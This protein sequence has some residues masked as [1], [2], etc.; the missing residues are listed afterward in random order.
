MEEKP[1]RRQ[2]DPSKFKS[3]QSIESTG[4]YN[5][6]YNKWAGF[7]KDYKRYLLDTLFKKC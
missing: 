2:A 6:W 7:D 5:I 1:A 4:T 3:T